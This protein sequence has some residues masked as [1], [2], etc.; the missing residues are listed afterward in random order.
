MS[1]HITA[2]KTHL[3]YIKESPASVREP[4]GPRAKATAARSPPADVPDPA[5]SSRPSAAG[6]R[7][8][9]AG[10]RASAAPGVARERQEHWAAAPT[11]VRASTCGHR[12][13][14]PGVGPPRSFP[15]HPPPP[16]LTC[17]LSSSV[18]SMGSLSI[19]GIVEEEGRQPPT[20]P[21]AEPPAAA[22]PDPVSPAGAA[23]V[24]ACTALARRGETKREIPPPGTLI[25]SRRRP[26][27]R[28]GWPGGAFASRASAANAGRRG[29]EGGASYTRRAPIL[30]ARDP[31]QRVSGNQNVE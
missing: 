10:G 23:A 22:N 21:H 7:G 1:P 14:R 30:R 20:A 24:P 28:R 26:S 13:P 11:G 19:P 4:P 3:S 5:R 8:P 16:R 25:G 9:R 27:A 6:P 12:G 29:R 2:I 17:G 15:Q 18:S 31:P